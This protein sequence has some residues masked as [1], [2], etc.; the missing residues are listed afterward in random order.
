MNIWT[1]ILLFILIPSETE[2]DHWQVSDDSKVTFS[3]N[4]NV[5]SFTCLLGEYNL[6][7]VL[8]SK[9]NSEGYQFDKGKISLE[10]QAFDC[11]NS[12][13]NKDLYRT[14]KANDYPRITLTLT[15]I[16]LK[17]EINGF[18]L[19]DINIGGEKKSEIIIDLEIYNTLNTLYLSGSKK[20]NMT[21]FGIT[22][23]SRLFGMIQVADDIEIDFDLVL[24]KV[25]E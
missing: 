25:F 17:T 13:M 16:L 8:I 3:G 4:T 11:G 15:R 9:D 24:V 20:F 23:P 1:F 21:E 5:N 2:T 22:P 18:G 10:I 7:E 6:H 12:M 19:F 14:L